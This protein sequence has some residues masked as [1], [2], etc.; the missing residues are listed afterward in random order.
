MMRKALIIIACLFL[1]GCANSRS[2]PYE[3]DGSE[4]VTQPNEVHNTVSEETKK[5]GSETKTTSKTNDMKTPDNLAKMLMAVENGGDKIGLYDFGTQQFTPAIDSGKYWLCRYIPEKESIVYVQKR[6]V[7]IY[8]MKT[9]KTR[10]LV[11]IGEKEEWG[12]DFYVSPQGT[13]LIFTTTIYPDEGS[14]LYIVNLENGD[15]HKFDNIAQAVWW[16]QRII[17]CQ[18]LA[19]NINKARTDSHLVVI[20]PHTYKSSIFSQAV[21]EIDSIIPLKDSIIIEGVKKQEKAKK[22]ED[23][24]KGLYV[25]NK[26]GEIE[27]TIFEGTRE[28][29]SHIERLDYS[30]DFSKAVYTVGDTAH[31]GKYKVFLVSSKDSQPE[32][33]LEGEYINFPNISEDGKYISFKKGSSSKSQILIYDIEKQEQ[34]EITPNLWDGESFIF[35][36]W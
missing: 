16:G 30:K 32:L 11:S 36:D 20:E 34:Y 28:E 3:N 15:H 22:P 17:A 35:Y 1:F 25:L 26:E 6:Q 21:S 7:L 12:T 33:I 8:D 2:Q 19:D 13:E 23:Q 24:L 27:K 5:D 9:K 10:E 4:K 18:E 14:F 31:G 29:Y